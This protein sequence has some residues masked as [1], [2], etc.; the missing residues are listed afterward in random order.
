MMHERTLGGERFGAMNTVVAL[1]IAAAKM[2][3]VILFFMHVKYSPPSRSSPSSPLSSG[4]RFLDLHA[5]RS[6][7]S[8][9]DALAHRL[10]AVNACFR[11]ARKIVRRRFVPIPTQSGVARFI[12]SVRWE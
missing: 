1:V 4:L 8:P 10:G 2:L 11:A 7:H 5:F 9:L 6:S 12:S 3:F